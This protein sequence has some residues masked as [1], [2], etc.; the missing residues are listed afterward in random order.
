MT[1][2]WHM[3]VETK[4]EV[5][6]LKPK[7][8]T[9]QMKAIYEQDDLYKKEDNLV[10]FENKSKL[11]QIQIRQRKKKLPLRDQHIQRIQ[12][13]EYYGWWHAEYKYKAQQKNAD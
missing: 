4:I 8:L 5:I 9:A 3:E 1:S 11:E 2:H 7:K 6:V 12:P 10:F 13:E